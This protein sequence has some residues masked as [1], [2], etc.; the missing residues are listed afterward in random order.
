MSETTDERPPT[1]V[2]LTS[3]MTSLEAALARACR[4]AEEH[5]DL[6]HSIDRNKDDYGHDQAFNRAIALIGVSAKAGMALA[7]MKSEFSA[8]FNVTRR[9]IQPGPD[10][11]LEAARRAG[12]KAYWEKWSAVFAR[13]EEKCRQIE[14]EEG[15]PPQDSEGS[16]TEK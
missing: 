3:G 11:A 5:F 9:N 13:E 15:A 8:K 6:A 12:D 7:K 14:A 2:P 10:P 16:N 1:K 4:E